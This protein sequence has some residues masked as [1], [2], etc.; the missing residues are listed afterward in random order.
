MIYNIALSF[1]EET[2]KQI[3]QFY[4]KFKD[5]L[6][7]DFGLKE[8]SIPHATIIKFKSQSELSKEELDN[9][10]NNIIVDLKVDFSGITFLPSHSKGC[11]IEI[12]ILKDQQL[13][14]IQNKLIERVQNHEIKSGI[15]HRFRPHI[16]FAKIND[17]K[18]N[19]KDLNYSILRKKQVNAKLVI[20]LADSNFEFYEL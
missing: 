19:L 20:G 3:Y 5:N 15:E 16:T 14:E 6:N 18:I 12:S 11:W 9:L 4:S 1:D 2:N 10:F 17:C 8:H 7:L 13:I